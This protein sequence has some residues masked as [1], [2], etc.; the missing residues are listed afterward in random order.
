MSEHPH[1]SLVK[2]IYEA[3]A[4]RDL[5]TVDSLHAD[6]CVLHV[7]GH[8]RLAR[9][10]QGRAGIMGVVREGLEPA[11]E[12]RTQVHDILASDDHAVALVHAVIERDGETLDQPLVQVFHIRDGRVAEIWEYLWDQAADAAFWAR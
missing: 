1:V 8:G 4:N 7:S 3:M 10:A 12:V 2:Q 6:D 11:L 5:A 9:D